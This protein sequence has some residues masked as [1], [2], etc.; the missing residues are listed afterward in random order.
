MSEIDMDR[1]N[2]EIEGEIRKY[3]TSMEQGLA[4]RY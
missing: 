2:T 3:A 4:L 1:I